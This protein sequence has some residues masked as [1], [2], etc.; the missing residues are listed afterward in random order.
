[1]LSGN[2]SRSDLGGVFSWAS[3]LDGSDEDFK[4]VSSGQEVDDFESVSD[5]S[6]G[7]DL[8]TGVSAVEL[9]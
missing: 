9:E 7:L 4:W 5:D 1:L 6:D 3:E 2:T 8:L